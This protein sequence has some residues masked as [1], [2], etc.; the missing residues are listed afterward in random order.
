MGDELLGP[1][2]DWRLNACVDYGADKWDLYASGYRT[3]AE[4]LTSHVRERGVDQDRLIYPVVFLWRHH[5]ELL[6]KS[7]IKVTSSLLDR[8]GASVEGHELSQLFGTAR[9]LLGEFSVTERDALPPGTAQRTREALRKFNSVD[10]TS[11]VFRYPVD[12]QAHEHLTGVRHI[13]FQVVED[14]MR[15]VSDALG[16]L[17]IALDMV[18][19][20]RLDQLGDC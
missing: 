12:K 14:Y 13:N 9:Q 18:D 8:R 5:L 11:Q 20:W 4:L 6:I 2:D 15:S 19:Q 7:I 17:L 1:G 16:E 3:A 10:A